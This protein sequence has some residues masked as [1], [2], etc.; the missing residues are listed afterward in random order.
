M[1]ET[2]EIPEKPKR[3]RP[4]RAVEETALAIPDPPEPPVEPVRIKRARKK[5]DPETAIQSDVSFTSKKGA[6]NFKAMRAP[7]KPKLERSTAEPNGYPQPTAQP[8]PYAPLHDRFSPYAH[9]AI[10]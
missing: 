7:P 9:S 4:R 1:E 5:P 2:Q 10:A 3:G 6:V 8:R